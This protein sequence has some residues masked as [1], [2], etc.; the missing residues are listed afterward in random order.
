MYIGGELCHRFFIC[1][2]EPPFKEDK[3][4]HMGLQSVMDYKNGKLVKVLCVLGAVIAFV[5]VILRF[6][7]MNDI[8]S[9]VQWSHLPYPVGELIFGIICILICIVILA[10][11]D[12]FDVKLKVVP[13]WLALLIFG[14]I[15]ALFGALWGGLLIIFGALIGM[16]EAL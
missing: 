7:R 4:Q 3:V 11:F 13:S 1:R 2:K 14:I 12:L 9:A 6:A 16:I 10:S 15:L 5:E 8:P